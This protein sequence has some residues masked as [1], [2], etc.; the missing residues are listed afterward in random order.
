ME[1]MNK[2]PTTLSKLISTNEMTNNIL[3]HPQIRQKRRQR[4]HKYEYKIASEKK[5]TKIEKWY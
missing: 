2:R 3:D 5:V 4:K 1:S